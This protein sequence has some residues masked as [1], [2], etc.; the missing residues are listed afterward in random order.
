MNIDVCKKVMNDENLKCV[1]ADENEIIF[2][3]DAKGIVP[4]LEFLKLYEEND[5]K[6]LYQADRI[7]GKAA[8]IIALHCGIK[9]IYSDVVS[10]SAMDI[11][12][13]NNIE[14]TY[15]V[16]V[17]K[18]LNRDK[19]KEGPFETALHGVDENSFDEALEIIKNTLDTMLKNRP[20]QQ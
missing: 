17:D 11:G 2:K 16:L 6:P 9:E 18:I 3:S 8:A 7:M 14:M 5:L 10:Q 20:V 19:S 15:G 1:V 12:E 13:R 4:M